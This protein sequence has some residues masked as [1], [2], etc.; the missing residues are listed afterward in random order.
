[1]PVA[2]QQST[3]DSLQG[4]ALLYTSSRNRRAFTLIELLVVIAIIAILAAMLLPS[5]AR[6]KEKA[7]RVQCLNNIKT[8]NLSLI[9]YSD[10][11]GRKFPRAGGNGTPY[12]IDQSFRD[13]FHT[14]YRISRV[15]FY[16]PSN[17]GWNRDDFWSWPGS[18]ESVMGY[19]YFA[20]DPS[21]DTNSALSRT[22][23]R[24]PAFA[25]K[26]TDNPFYT[27]LFAD[28]VRKLDNSWLRPGDNDPLVR[29]VNHFNQNG[30]EPDGANEGFLDGRASWV[31]GAK[32]TR[33][34]KLSFGSTQV[35]FY[36]GDV[37]P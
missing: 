37:N 34:P 5:L 10:D 21:Y 13:L 18:K 32:F 20:G 16:C 31:K 22:L 27:V 35:Y 15:Q 6:A 25:Q 3:Q 36:G 8:W 4:R 33:F 26:N 17:P 30:R 12:W 7:K 23:T 2:N 19:L 24:R 29:G 11:Y 28:L 14:N 9:I 1:M